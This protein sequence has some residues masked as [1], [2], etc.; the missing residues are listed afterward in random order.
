MHVVAVIQ[1]GGSEAKQAEPTI[2]RVKKQIVN[3]D[4]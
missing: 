3:L 1:V 2:R 4:G